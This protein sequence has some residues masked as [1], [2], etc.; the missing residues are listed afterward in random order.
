ME[1]FICKYCDRECKNLNSL[2]N[3]ERLCKKNPD[4]QEIVSNFIKFN[5]ERK[6]K[7]LPGV[8]KG[9]T[10][11]NCEWK[12]KATEKLKN[13]YDSG[14]IVTWNKGLTKDSDERVAKYAQF[15]SDTM[16]KKHES[17]EAYYWGK[18]G[19][20]SYPEQYFLD[21]FSSPEFC[22]NDFIHN[23][24]LGPYKLDF[25]W[26]D[27]KLCIEV[28]GDQH[29]RTQ[30]R[31]DSDTRRDKYCE[32]RGWTIIRIKWSD[33]DKLNRKEREEFIDSLNNDVSKILDL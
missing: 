9:K 21:I 10:K 11:D 13:R 15:V 1:K 18:Y 23:Y 24:H 20:L 32:E 7:G 25:A 6:E 3:H 22:N 8:N 5:Q 31:I 14:E 28:D 27:Q 17:G 12:R 26:P 2:K 16:K 19:D 30:K 33:F 29:Y 4:R